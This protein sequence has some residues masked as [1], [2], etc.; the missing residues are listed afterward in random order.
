MKSAVVVFLFSP[1]GT[2]AESSDWIRSS[3]AVSREKNVLV[4]HFL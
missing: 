2:M 4:V 3:A 1:T